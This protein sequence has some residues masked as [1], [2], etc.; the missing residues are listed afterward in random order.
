[1]KKVQLISLSLEEFQSLVNEGL[2]NELDEIK[3]NLVPREPTVY[4]TRQ[5]VA[6]MLK[7]DLSTVHNWTKAGRLRRYT[8]GH[9]VYYKR[10]EI[11]D[12]LLEE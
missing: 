3:R 12:S 2:R 5:E 8:I 7:V 4:L 10:S 1:M 6:D 11:E 9:R